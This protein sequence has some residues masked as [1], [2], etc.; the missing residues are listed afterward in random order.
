MIACWPVSTIE[1]EQIKYQHLERTYNIY[2]GKTRNHVKVSDTVLVPCSL[3]ALQN[4][5]LFKA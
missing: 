5:L 2:N 3:S 4:V 1:G